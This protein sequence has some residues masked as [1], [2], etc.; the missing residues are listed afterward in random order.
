MASDRASTRPTGDNR[1][2]RIF[3]VVELQQI[4]LVFPQNAFYIV[5]SAVSQLDPYDFGR[6]PTKEAELMEILIF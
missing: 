6:C 2:S 1:E 4:R 3:V 5:G